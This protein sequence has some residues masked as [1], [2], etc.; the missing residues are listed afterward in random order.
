MR[1]RIAPAV[2]MCFSQAET[3]LGRASDKLALLSPYGVLDRGYSLATNAVGEIVRDAS[4]LKT[5]DSLHV[6]FAKG[7]VEATVA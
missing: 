7:S 2:R 1:Q 4:A 5:G 6:R 3:R